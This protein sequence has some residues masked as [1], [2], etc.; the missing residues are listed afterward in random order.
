[1]LRVFLKM[2]LESTAH[3][4]KI[5]VLLFQY[6]PWLDRADTSRKC[7][8]IVLANAFASDSLTRRCVCIKSFLFPIT[9]ITES[10]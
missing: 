4:F 9:N 3:C 1:M 7:P 2:V 8:P 10:K 6:L 5:T